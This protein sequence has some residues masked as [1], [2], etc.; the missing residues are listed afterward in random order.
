MSEEGD[1][2]DAVSFKLGRLTEAV[3]ANYQAMTD[4]KGV[5]KS[6]Y[7]NCEALKEYPAIKKLLDEVKG[8]LEAHLNEHKL[9]KHYILINRTKLIGYILALA[10]VLYGI[11]T[12]ISERLGWMH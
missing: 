10:S 3:Q 8:L 6:Q 4:L 5:V 9:K 7:E 2:I 1:G 12:F 11:L